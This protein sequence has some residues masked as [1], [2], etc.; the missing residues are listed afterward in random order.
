MV[1]VD[2]QLANIARGVPMDGHLA[3]GQPWG[4]S[5]TPLHVLAQV[6]ADPASPRVSKANEG[7]SWPRQERKQPPLQ[8]DLMAGSGA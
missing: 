1:D 2:G 3:V 6:R 8:Q 4:A 5:L 7:I